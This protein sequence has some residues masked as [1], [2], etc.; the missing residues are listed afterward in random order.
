MEPEPQRGEERA[1][2]FRIV[3]AGWQLDRAERMPLTES[4]EA[5]DVAVSN[6]AFEFEL[7]EVPTFLW[8]SRTS[9]PADAG[10]PAADAG[11]PFADAGASRADARPLEMAMDGAAEADA[12]LGSVGEPDASPMRASNDRANGGCSSL[13]AGAPGVASMLLIGVLFAVRRRR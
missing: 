2:P 10:M 9:P 1:T 13:H 3:A 6:E 8:V 11:S 12:S 4:T 7:S 5:V